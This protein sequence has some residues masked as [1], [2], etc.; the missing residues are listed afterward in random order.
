MKSGDILGGIASSTNTVTGVISGLASN[1]GT[2]LPLSAVNKNNSDDDN[3]DQN[4]QDN[5]V[6]KD[7]LK[8]AQANNNFYANM[9][10]NLG[11]NKSSSNSKS[12]NEFG[13]V[14][15]IRGK[16]ENSSITYNNVKNIE[17]VGTQAKDTK[18]I[19]N[20]V[21]NINKTAVELNNSYSSTSKSSGISAGATINYNNGFQ[22]EANA[23]SISASKSN[24][25]SNGTIYQNGRFVNVDEVHNNT[26]NMTLSGFNQ[27]GGTVTG[28]I[29][30]LTI[31]SKQNTST[32]KGSTKG[33]SLSVSANGIPSGSANYSKT[34]GERRVVDN[35]STFII[36]DGSDLKVAK[37]ENTA[38]AIGTTENGKLSI[39]EYVGYNLE[40]VDKLKT[41]GGS[42]G[43]S[44]SGVTSIGVNYS[45]KK[46]EGITKNT[47]IGNVEIGK[48]SGDEINK[49]LDT[50][51]EITEDR[52]FKTNV[53]VE[54]QTIKYALNPSQF[55]E[56][57]QIA[58]IEG[59]ATGRTV[60][61]TIDNVI[62]GD[63]SQDIGD[64]ERRSLIEIKEA[65]VRVQTAPAMDIIAEKD[66][67]DKNIQARLGVEIEKFDPNDPTLSEKVRER[68][69]ELKAEGKEIVAFYDKV[70]KK[71]FINQNAKDEEVRASIAREYKI[72]EDLELGRGKE[73]DKGQL[74]STVAG[75]IAY[76]EIK[77]RLKKGDKNPISAS[78]F[79]V[80]KM[81]KDSEVT[82]DGYTDY[83]EADLK[84]AGTYVK[85][86]LISGYHDFGLWFL[87]SENR[88][89][90]YAESDKIQENFKNDLKAIDKELEEALDKERKAK[91][92]LPK[93]E[94]VLSNT[95][96]PNVRK[97]FENYFEYLKRQ[98]DTD[99]TFLF[100]SYK[101]AGIG[102]AEGTIEFYAAEV[103]GTATV[104]LAGIS[105]LFRGDTRIETP[106]E[107]KKNSYIPKENRI[108]ITSSEALKLKKFFPDYYTNQM[109]H[110]NVLGLVENDGI[111]RN[112]ST[113]EN[114]PRISEDIAAY[115]NGERS[116]LENKG[117]VVGNIVGNIAG[118]KL[119]SEG[120]FYKNNSTNITDKVETPKIKPVEDII[121]TKT[122]NKKLN[123][124]INT[125]GK[126]YYL[127]QLDEK[128]APVFATISDEKL[129]SFQN[130][131]NRL[132]YNPVLKSPVKYP[133]L[134][135]SENKFL[136]DYMN[137]E[138]PGK[139]VSKYNDV[140]KYEY[141]A[142]TNPGPLSIG[143]DPAINNFYG[144]M[145]NDASNESGIFVRMGDKI[146]PYGSWYTK[147]SKNSEVE[148]RV[149]LAIKKWW[150][151]P[152]GEIKI[153]GL[154][155]EKS[156]LDT[157]YY[158]KFP[159][160]I[161]KYK[162]PVGYQG[163]PF[164]GGLDQEQYFIP[165]SWEYGEIIETY[166]VK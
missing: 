38:S 76:D 59:K 128:K 11:F 5:T 151:K 156:I 96:N 74:R 16:D 135:D 165:D 133:N 2:K 89:K 58:I 46:Q 150:V 134:T 29:E 164:L 92:L 70:T 147:V 141:N 98:S 158:I 139:I 14:T 48:S 43:V 9:G 31:E 79:D 104:A 154:E 34:N 20:N 52:D 105:M 83:L 120:A 126:E 17:Y 157:M 86:S 131:A 85:Y 54:S 28:N 137:K 75:E 78:S 60:V 68:I 55:K 122:G 27:E 22:A 94:M 95:K 145:Y 142:T 123:N 125:R 99:D 64:A 4:N 72:K 163:G 21:E 10:V 3:D 166:P 117:Y 140:N 162:G 103:L 36:G 136:N 61:K 97:A 153:R 149:D 23:V 67:A 69:D 25:N 100:N 80:A 40:N 24:M 114:D 129:T 121:G 93:V 50:M 118:Y 6:G 44:T 155:A 116:K 88:K 77:D 42:V 82:A 66:L 13:V 102:L 47:V 12:H 124:A 18:F 84:K 148:A 30:N 107:N 143:D 161:P 53:N 109:G 35:A 132:P 152:N 56:D 51:T 63:K 101:G 33:G 115:Y 112:T 113:L 87:S 119:A 32:T 160:G 108:T 130:E 62:N 15:T 19:Y 39:D 106:K 45:D 144:G 146:K 111:P 90:H 91:E 41:A 71:I 26:K 159:E 73:N 49:D 8:A 1:Q 110:Y 7:N 127:K 65:I 138:M 57:L 37:V 81:D